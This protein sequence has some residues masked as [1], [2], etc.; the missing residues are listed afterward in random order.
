VYKIVD[1]FG[2]IYQTFLSGYGVIGDMGIVGYLGLAKQKT[3]IN[4]YY[5]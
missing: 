5:D 1:N 3:L 2:G 4:M